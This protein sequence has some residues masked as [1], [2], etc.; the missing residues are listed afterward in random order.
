MNKSLFNAIKDLVF[1]L[2]FF[3]IGLW[4]SRHFF[5]G[6]V[7]IALAI[8]MVLNFIFTMI[9]TMIEESLR[10]GTL[11]EKEADLQKRKDTVKVAQKKISKKVGDKF[12]KK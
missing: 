7:L 10:P 8:M 5:N 3:L 4:I 11:D 1:M 12:K 2:G 9:V 6:S